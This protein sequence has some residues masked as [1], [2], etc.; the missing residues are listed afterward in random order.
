M[1]SQNFRRIVQLAIEII[2]RVIC[3]SQSRKDDS[4]RLVSRDG[5][6]ASESIRVVRSFK[7]RS[8]L[9]C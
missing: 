3:V 8:S 1:I 5:L 6:N 2:E 9:A 7:V 4:R